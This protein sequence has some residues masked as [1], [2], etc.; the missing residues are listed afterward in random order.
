MISRDAAF[1]IRQCRLGARK[2][3]PGVR[4]RYFQG[5]LVDQEEILILPDQL[6]FIEKTLVDK[7][8][9]PRTDIDGIDCLHTSDEFM[10]RR[11]VLNRHGEDANGRTSLCRHVLRH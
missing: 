6:A 10:F 1:S 9:D 7:T 3:C 5:P 11:N 8:F 2:R 4:Q